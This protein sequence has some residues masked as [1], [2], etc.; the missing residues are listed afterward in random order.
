MAAA[1]ATT[2]AGVVVANIVYAGQ[3][4]AQQAIAHPT[5][6]KAVIGTAA[7]KP[8]APTAPTT[9]RAALNWP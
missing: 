9:G 8:G 5:T 1:Q 2:A 6:T 4:V 7:P 3:V